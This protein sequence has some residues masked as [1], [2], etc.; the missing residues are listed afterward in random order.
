MCACVCAI[1]GAVGVGGAGEGPTGAPQTL[2]S[3]VFEGRAITGP[4]GDALAHT[5]GD[6]AAAV[7]S[8]GAP[9]S[10]HYKH[11]HITSL[12]FALQS[13]VAGTTTASATYLLLIFTYSYIYYLVLLLLS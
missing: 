5:T 10:V 8:P 2:F 9:P 4:D 3:K 7:V 1:T 12:I 11:I 13:T 6:G